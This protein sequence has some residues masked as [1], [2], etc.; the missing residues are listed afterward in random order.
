[1]LKRR[2]ECGETNNIFSNINR[3]TNDS[4]W[5]WTRSGISWQKTKNIKNENG[6]ECI[7]CV[8]MFCLYVCVRNDEMINYWWMNGVLKM[9]LIARQFK[10]IIIPFW[11]LHNK[12]FVSGYCEELKHTAYVVLVWITSSF[13]R[14]LLID[15]RSNVCIP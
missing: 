10:E 15:W 4:K 8:F 3:T 2:N 9:R 11:C 1:M 14:I 7:L 13:L 12:I 5:T 6:I